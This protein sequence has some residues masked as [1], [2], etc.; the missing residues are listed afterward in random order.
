MFSGG[1]V[2]LVMAAP[3]LLQMEQLQRIPSLIVG[4]RKEK[5]IFPQWQ[6]PEY[7]F[8][9]ANRQYGLLTRV[10]KSKLLNRL[11]EQEFIIKP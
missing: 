11:P 2:K 8:M 7:C 6:L 9:P 1:I 4:E 5:T 10:S 3:F